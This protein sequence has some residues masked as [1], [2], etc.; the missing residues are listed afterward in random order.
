MSP[1]L[2][3]IGPSSWVLEVEDRTLA[4]VE[5]VKDVT[6]GKPDRWVITETNETTEDLRGFVNAL[7]LPL[8]NGDLT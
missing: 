3:K 8:R 2:R 7:T 5:R 6:I 4:Y 1:T